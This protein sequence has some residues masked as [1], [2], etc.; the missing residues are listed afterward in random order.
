MK[1]DDSRALHAYVDGE[2]DAAAILE[3]EARMAADP[4]LRAAYERLRDTSAAVRAHAEYYRAPEHLRPGRARA[5]RPALLAA[6]FAGVAA[7]A[8]AAGLL[9]SRPGGDDALAREAV[10]SHVRATLSGRLIEVASS[11][12][13]TVKPWFSARLPFS[14]AVT[15]FPASGFELVGGR[16][17]T[18]GG[19]PVAVM[20]Y[21]RRQ[22]VIDVYVGRGEAATRG[23]T[24]DGFNVEQFGATGLRYYA[25]SDLNRNE[26]ADFVGLLR[27]SGG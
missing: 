23:F 7:V 18:L 6:A 22:H 14:P 24:Q 9:V 27:K 11:D 1:T 16:L 17:D 19:E 13:H 26:L 8:F 12:Q 3:L 21:K 20:V 2:L 15:D 10:A 4:A 5:R 25:V